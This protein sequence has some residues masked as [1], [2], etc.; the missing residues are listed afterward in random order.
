[1]KLPLKNYYNYTVGFVLVYSFLTIIISSYI[2]W[3]VLPMGQGMG[4]NK[5][6]PTRLTGLG[7]QGNSTCAF[8]WPKHM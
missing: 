6:C 2:L 3:F 8:D 4:G 7:V 5:V 1:M